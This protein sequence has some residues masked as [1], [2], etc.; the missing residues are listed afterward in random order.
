MKRLTREG[1]VGFINK[2]PAGRGINQTGFKTCAVGDYVNSVMGKRDN[3]DI[4]P[5]MASELTHQLTMDLSMC[6]TYGA[7]Q[8]V[9]R[10]RL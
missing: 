9:I 1:F 4:Y 8:R 7:A 10:K 5:F 3:D 6:E 2:Q